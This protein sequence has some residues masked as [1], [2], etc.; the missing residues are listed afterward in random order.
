M[1]PNLSFQQVFIVYFSPSLDH[2]KAARVLLMLTLPG[3]LIFLLTISYVQ[4]GHTS[5]T[6]YFAGGY[7]ACAILQVSRNL[8][9]APK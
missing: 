4:A 6:L 9:I 3:H 5:L 7:F 8:K 1:S 2:G